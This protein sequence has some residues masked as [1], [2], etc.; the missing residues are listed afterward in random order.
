MSALGEFLSAWLDAEP[1]QRDV[2]LAKM[3]GEA[4]SSPPLGA[5]PRDC[6]KAEAVLDQ[7]INPLSL[8]PAHQ[9]TAKRARRAA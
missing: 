3:R 6:S 2:V 5:A 9:R 8:N 4:P 1:W 7:N